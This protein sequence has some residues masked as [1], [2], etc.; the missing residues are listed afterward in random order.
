MATPSS[1][2]PPPPPAELNPA[3]E[4]MGQREP[5]RAMMLAEPLLDHDDPAVAEEAKRVVAVASFHTQDF[6][7]SAELYEQLA[8]GSEASFDWFNYAT[9]SVMADLPYQ[10]EAALLKALE[11]HPNQVG[12]PAPTVPQMRHYLGCALRDRGFFERALLQL[13]ELR[14]YY[15]MVRVTDDHFVYVRGL[16]FFSSTLDLAVDVFR[17]LNNPDAAAAWFD[18]FATEVDQEGAERLTEA[19]A[20]IE[21]P[22]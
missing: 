18:G 20:R 5:R 19:K 11:F 13:D 7:R 10:G 9:S 3:W 17:G 1:T 6:T 8:A 22:T 2:P 21:N 4:A 16:P 12:P 15:G 14:R